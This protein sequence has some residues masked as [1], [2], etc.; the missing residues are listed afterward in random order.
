MRKTMTEINNGKLRKINTFG[1]KRGTKRDRGPASYGHL[2]IVF[3]LISA[4][5]H[6]STINPQEQ[7][8]KT[9]KTLH[10]KEK[11]C[12]NLT[13]TYLTIFNQALTTGFIQM[14]QLEFNRVVLSNFLKEYRLDASRKCEGRS[15]QM[16]GPVAF[17]E[18]LRI[19]V[20]EKVTL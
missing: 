17:I 16:L 2:C 14:Y 1:Q 15:F 10:S 20:R 9:K 3:N 4:K 8:F 19:F 7:S 18:K 11:N 6:S 13:I 5:Q 12:I